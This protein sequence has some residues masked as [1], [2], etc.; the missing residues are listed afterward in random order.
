MIL[1]SLINTFTELPLHTHSLILYTFIETYTK[2][3]IL[4]LFITDLN[5]TEQ[6]Y[7][8]ELSQR[9]KTLRPINFIIVAKIY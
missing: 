6:I 4:R 5:K 2:K 7:G 8:V 9:K 3:S 1:A